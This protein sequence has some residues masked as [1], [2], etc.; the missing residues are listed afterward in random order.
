MIPASLRVFGIKSPMAPA[1]SQSPVKITTPRGNGI[2][3][4]MI[5]RK[6]CGERT[7]SAPNGA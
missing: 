2:P 4:G 1:I 5:A 6:P 3:G 7:C